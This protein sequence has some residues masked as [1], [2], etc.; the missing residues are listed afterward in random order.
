MDQV[1]SFTGGVRL[2]PPTVTAPKT[3][4]GFGRVPSVL[5][6]VCNHGLR[7]AEGKDIKVYAQTSYIRAEPWT[8]Q[9]RQEMQT[10]N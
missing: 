9:S 2:D 6:C 3:K 10:E 1:T 8:Q 5:R 4:Q 7:V